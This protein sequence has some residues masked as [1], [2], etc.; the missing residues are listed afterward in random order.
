MPPPEF[1][2][3]PTRAPN[4]DKSLPL[5]AIA[6]AGS[7]FALLGLAF[8]RHP[9]YGLFAYLLA[10][11]NHPPTRWWGSS[12]PDLRWSLLAAVVA[13]IASY[14]YEDPQKKALRREAIKD[15]SAGQRLRDLLAI[16]GD[17]LGIA[18][19]L[20]LVYAVYMWIQLAWA[21]WFNAA[22]EGCVLFTKYVVLIV[23]M[24]RTLD[25]KERLDQ[26]AWAHIA[27][28]FVFGWIAWMDPKLDEGRLERIGGPGVSDS[29]T[30]AVHMATGLIF[31]GFKLFSKSW[32]ER[33]IAVPACAWIL[34]GIILCGS[35][36]AL[37][38]VAAGGLITLVWTPRSKRKALL[39]LSALGAVML[40]V[41]AHDLFWQ[42]METIDDYKQD[43]SANSRIQLIPAHMKM[44]RDFPLGVGHDGFRSLSPRYVPGHLLSQDGTRSPH[45][46]I[47]A[48]LSHQGLPGVLIYAI[49]MFV[50]LR[51]LIRLRFDERRSIKDESLQ[52]NVTALASSFAV[53]G[54][55]G[56]FTN[57]LKAEA[58][59]WLIGMMAAVVREHA[60]SAWAARSGP[61]ETAA[62]LHRSRD[63]CYVAA[64][65]S[66]AH[67]LT[68]SRSGGIS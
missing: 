3:K 35:R 52:L 26:F 37:V 28:C 24:V 16:E 20:L 55:A 7:Y 61:A 41:L 48:V 45:T 63:R 53:F 11:Y 49:L 32:I 57:Y 9:V 25:S 43:K 34:N 54:V 68:N 18:G 67:A 13:L 19:K 29:N 4:G 42:R 59:I 17:T 38:G 15:P 47:L 44:F 60:R 33:L 66:T 51:E 58:Q 22:L 62:S 27:G 39:G 1:P 30:L 2:V 21:V 8:L 64:A 23:L 46:T 40:L 5:T 56:I 14:V 6:F 36:G 10:F 31:A 65:E 50:L 12:L